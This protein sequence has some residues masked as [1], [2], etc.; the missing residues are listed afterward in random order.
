MTWTHRTHHL[1]HS[2][3]GWSLAVSDERV[4][5]TLAEKAMEGVLAALGHPCCGKGPL[6]HLSV[7]YRTLRSLGLPV[8][9]ET[10]RCN[11]LDEDA[12]DLLWHKVLNLPN[13]LLV[14]HRPLLSLPL[15]KEQA[16]VINPEFVDRFE[17]LDDETHAT[18]EVTG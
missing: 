11:E 8:D 6:A 16:R 5:G 4:V 1:T 7:S 2:R 10:V 18:D 17:C 15:T 9:A 12:L 13:R 3:D 14:P